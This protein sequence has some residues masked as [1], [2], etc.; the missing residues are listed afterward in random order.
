MQPHAPAQATPAPDVDRARTRTILTVLVLATFVVILNETIMTNAIPRLMRELDVTASTAQW[1]S[2]VFML[3]MAVVIPVSG[4]LMERLATRRTFGLAMTLFSVGTAACLLAP[5]FG[6]LVGGRVVQACGTAIMMPLLMTTLMTLVPAHGRGRVMGNVTLVISVAPAM[7][8]AVS[9]LLLQLGSWRLIFAAVL[10]IAV[11]ALVVGLRALVDV[12]EPGHSDLDLVSLALSAV[13]FGGLVYGLS[14]LGEGASHGAAS[15]GLPPWG[16]LL[17]GLVAMG[18]F[19]WRQLVLQRHGTP[20]LDLRTLSHRTFTIGLALMVLCFMGL[21][22]TV[23]LLPIY[24]QEVRG[25]SSLTTGLLMIPG[26]LAMGLLGPQVGKAYDRYGAPRLVVPGA[27][28][29]VAGLVMLALLAPALAPWGVLAL[30]VLISVSLALVFTPV[31]T[32]SLGV[33]PPHLYPHG[34]AILGSLQQVGAAAGTATTVAV[35]TSV[36]AR[37]AAGGASAAGALTSG[38][39]GGFAVGAVLAVLALGASTLVRT[40]RS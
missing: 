34:S 25:L 23:I 35:M 2:T 16:C 9:G 20:L 24:L 14:G 26:G 4:W 36:T 39:Q 38:V 11:G 8:P 15:S 29:L 27:A 19:T 33:L 7:G 18:A 28:G 30:H 13:G 31:F 37:A 21:M 12:A 17:V 40:P 1:L 22:G 5:T 32:A 3:T 10:P 6:V